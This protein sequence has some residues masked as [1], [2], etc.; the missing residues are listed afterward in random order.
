MGR[1]K[2]MF[3]SRWYPTVQ[4]STGGRAAPLV[5]GILSQMTNL[6]YD[7]VTSHE[8]GA[9]PQATINGFNGQTGIDPLWSFIVA[10]L[11]FQIR[12]LAPPGHFAPE[13][14]FSPLTPALSPLRGEGGAVGAASN[15]NRFSV[16][17]QLRGQGNEYGNEWPKS[18]KRHRGSPLPSTG[19]GP[20]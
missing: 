11:R 15:S 18:E 5:R 9:R 13:L 17:R 14:L 2:E 10:H 12:T 16:L 1:G 19:R 8:L 3:V 4:S 20:G 6:R 7:F